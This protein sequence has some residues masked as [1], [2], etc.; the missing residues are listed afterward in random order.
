MGQITAKKIISDIVSGIRDSLDTGKYTGEMNVLQ[1]DHFRRESL[2][3]EAVRTLV[4]AFLVAVIQLVLIISDS[5]TGFYLTVRSAD[6]NKAAEIILLTV[7]VAEMIALGHMLSKKD[8]KSESLEICCEIYYAVFAVGL[9]L[10]FVSDSLRS[11]FSYALI[12]AAV[13]YGVIVFYDKQMSKAGLWYFAALST[14]C[15]LFVTNRDLGPGYTAVYFVVLAAAG[16]AARYLRTRSAKN[17]MINEKLA[18]AGMT[19]GL[20][21]I[22]NWNALDKYFSDFPDCEGG[23]FVAVSDLDFFRVFNDTEGHVSGDAALK[24]AAKCIYEVTLEKGGFCTRYGGDEFVSIFLN[25]DQETAYSYLDEIGKRVEKEG[26]KNSGCSEGMQTLS[27]GYAEKQDEE[28]PGDALKRA[29]KALD[30]AKETGG[31]KVTFAIIN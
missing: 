31:N 15:L 11:V 19:D 28:S 25:T 5:L 6:M 10:F 8:T 1:E 2:T 12:A 9:T 7:S 21:G 26:I 20:T 16:L 3:A 17:F 23:Y 14:V 13:M 4:A 22:P 24:K 27:I 30:G 18:L 29:E